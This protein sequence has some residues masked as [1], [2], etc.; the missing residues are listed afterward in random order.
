MPSEAIELFNEM[1]RD[2]VGYVA[3]PGSGKST[4][5][6]TQLNLMRRDK[7]DYFTMS[8]GM[9]TCT[10]GIMM[11]KDVAK[12]NELRFNDPINPLDMQGLENERY[13]YK[14]IVILCVLCKAL[15]LPSLKPRLPIDAIRSIVEAF[16]LIDEFNI[17]APWPT[18]FVQIPNRDTFEVGSKQLPREHAAAY[19]RILCEEEY[20]FV[21]PDNCAIET[22]SLPE[23]KNGNRFDPDYWEGVRNLHQRLLACEDIVNNVDRMAYA[24]RIIDNLDKNSKDFFLHL[25]QDLFISHAEVEVKLALNRTRE[26][27]Y[28]LFSEQR[29]KQLE[30]EI[31]FEEFLLMGKDQLTVD[32][33]SKVDFSKV[34]FYD[35]K[36]AVMKD[37]VDREKRGMV[38]DMQEEKGLRELHK[39]AVKNLR[40]RL[41]MKEELLLECAAKYKS[42]LKH[43]MDSLCHP[44]K[45]RFYDS[46]ALPPSLL[47]MSEHKRK[48]LLNRYKEEAKVKHIPFRASEIIWTNI[49]EAWGEATCIV[50]LR[51]KSMISKAKRWKHQVQVFGSRICGGCEG[52]FSSNNVKC[53]SCPKDGYLF[54]IDMPTH[55]YIC[56]GCEKIGVINFAVCSGCKRKCDGV[57]A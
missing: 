22:F 41:E 27:L 8:S 47:G 54:W 48:K 31:T 38:L 13:I 37:F 23:F 26:Q 4:L 51:W 9:E 16:K 15:V 11:L 30:N 46:L 33:S 29:F 45:M 34:A 44:D 57:L 18:V 20:E 55:Y 2:C 5:C 49:H 14:M 3:A 40:E 7:T 24:Q 50:K 21:L 36:D 1:Y 25:N 53:T 43:E 42:W 39:N 32:Y 17:K 19:I 6:S 28:S 35:A 10:K 12:R 52:K 56:K